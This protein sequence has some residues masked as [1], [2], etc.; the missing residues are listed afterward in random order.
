M[1]REKRSKQYSRNKGVLF[2]RKIAKMLSGW[3][4]DTFSRTPL[5]GGWQKKR[6]EGK[7]VRGDIITPDNFPF[8]VECKKRELW[9]LDNVSKHHFVPLRWYLTLEKECGNDKKPL[10]FFTKNNAPIFVMTDVFLSDS[11]FNIRIMHPKKHH[12]LYIYDVQD[13]M[14]LMPAGENL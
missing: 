10:L 11:P 9:T 1:E 4:G 6:E 3:W 5:S 7:R 8:L 14:L 13:F 12:G 2:E